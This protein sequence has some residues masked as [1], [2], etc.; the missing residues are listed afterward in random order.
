VCCRDSPAYQV[1]P[2]VASLVLDRE[3]PKRECSD[4]NSNNQLPPHAARHEKIM[5]LQIFRTPFLQGKRCERPPNCPRW[6]VL[7]LL[8]ALIDVS[9]PMGQL[10]AFD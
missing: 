7:V 8:V 2:I 4:K 10:F 3:N 1:S 9:F 5:V 6:R